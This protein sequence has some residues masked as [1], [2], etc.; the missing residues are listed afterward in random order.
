MYTEEFNDDDDDDDDDDD[1]D[2]PDEADID[3]ADYDSNYDDDEAFSSPYKAEA[4]AKESQR[5]HRIAPHHEKKVLE[6]KLDSRENNTKQKRDIL[7]D[8]DDDALDD[9]DDYTL[10]L[11]LNWQANLK[12]KR[13]TDR[14]NHHHSF[15]KSFVKRQESYRGSSSFR[16]TLKDSS[17]EEQNT[18]VAI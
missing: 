12:R 16:E 14:E 15:K 11:L 8:T 5:S 1:P 17:D 6:E 3:N 9:T 10:D 13:S 18:L 2:D 4:E 7:D